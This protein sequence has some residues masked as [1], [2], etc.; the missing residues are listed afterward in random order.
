MPP[1][2][3]GVGEAVKLQQTEFRNVWDA[4]HTAPSPAPSHEHHH[5]HPPH[6]HSGS[7]HH[8]HH[9]DKSQKHAP[10]A[11]PPI[12]PWERKNRVVT[13]VFDD[14]VVPP[15][16]EFVAPEEIV[17]DEEEDE[18]EYVEDDVVEVDGEVD[19]IVEGM[20]FSLND[21]SEDDDEY[22]P[23][24]GK[25]IAYP[26]TPF[27]SIRGRRPTGLPGVAPEFEDD[28]EE[29]GEVVNDI[30]M[31]RTSEDEYGSTDEWDPS[32]KLEE[33]RRASDRL[34]SSQTSYVP[35]D[36]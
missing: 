2:A 30:R 25:K 35:D 5:H 17:D 6:H 31:R 18:Y 24:G 36:I 20:S 34:S 4:N 23:S 12:F 11:P 33:L 29:G 28:E 15:Y 16:A 9:S 10:S 21:I 27:A 22:T 14:Y 26:V 1:P 8:H 3:R 19:D 7:H 32:L 13:R